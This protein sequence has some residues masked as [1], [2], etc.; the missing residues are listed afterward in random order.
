MLDSQ[1]LVTR[2]VS[3]AFIFW[4]A[5]EAWQ[6]VSC[7][8]LWGTYA[9]RRRR[10]KIMSSRHGKHLTLCAKNEEGSKN[11]RRI[12]RTSWGYMKCRQ[13]SA[14]V[15][16][17]NLYKCNCFL[18]QII[19]SL[20]RNKRKRQIKYTVIGNSALIIRACKVEWSQ[21]LWGLNDNTPSIYILRRWSWS[22]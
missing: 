6:R 11:S 7:L 3:T 18:R 16:M 2:P 5:C 4:M 13:I 1:I 19:Q 12:I 17:Y 22:T 9:M 8:Y 10:L 20:S 15:W 14:H 21:L